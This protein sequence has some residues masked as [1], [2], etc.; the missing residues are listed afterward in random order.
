VCVI[1][2]SKSQEFLLKVCR[3][4]VFFRRQRHRLHVNAS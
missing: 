3:L 4:F 1:A 2:V